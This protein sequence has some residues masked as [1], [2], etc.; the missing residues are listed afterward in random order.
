MINGN[1]SKDKAK[2]CEN[3]RYIGWQW[4]A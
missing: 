4:S 1:G 2:L 3:D